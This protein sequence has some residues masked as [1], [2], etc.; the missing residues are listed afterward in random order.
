[1]FADRCSNDPLMLDPWTFQIS[2]RAACRRLVQRHSRND[3]SEFF[4]N[5]RMMLTKITRHLWIADEL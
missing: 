5:F 3:S 1:M 4:K 2:D